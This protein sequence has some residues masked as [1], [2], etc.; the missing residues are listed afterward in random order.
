MEKEKKQSEVEKRQANYRIISQDC[1]VPVI[2]KLYICSESQKVA[3]M[4][5]P[6]HIREAIRPRMPLAHF[7][8][9]PT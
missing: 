8:G 1:F 9:F 5:S 4:G 2:R 3:N 6:K 7:S